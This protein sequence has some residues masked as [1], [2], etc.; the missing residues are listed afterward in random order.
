VSIKF[1]LSDNGSFLDIEEFPKRISKGS[2]LPSMDT[3]LPWRYINTCPDQEALVEDRFC[4][5]GCSGSGNQASLRP[6]VVHIV[7]IATCCTTAPQLQ[8]GRK[9][10]NLRNAC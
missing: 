4:G 9:A 8:Q 3:P 6:S 5:V 10:V 1:K 7:R 2:V